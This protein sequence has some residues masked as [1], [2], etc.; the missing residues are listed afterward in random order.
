M[1]N[2]KVTSELS[3]VDR[4]RDFL[5][6]S[7]KNVNLKEEAY[8]W[9]ELSL[10]EMS[11]NIVRYAYPEGGGDIWLT[12]WRE[13]DWLHFEIRDKGIPFDP[14]KAEKPDIEEMIDHRQKG[15]LGIYLTRKLMDRFDYR[16]EG[17]QNILIMSKRLHESDLNL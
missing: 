10:V 5:Q 17:K 11:I 1:K 8:Y 9:I 13:G 16:R 7:L 4:I 6:E 3:Q 14:S 15:G 2:I 12:V